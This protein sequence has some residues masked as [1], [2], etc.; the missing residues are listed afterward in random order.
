MLLTRKIKKPDL[1][2]NLLE[3]KEVNSYLSDLNK[4]KITLLST[5]AGYG[6]TTALNYF[7][8]EMQ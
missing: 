5:P 7:L 2:P 6:K 4:Y 8:I 1:L 3:R